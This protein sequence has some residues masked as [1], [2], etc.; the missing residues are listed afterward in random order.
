MQWFGDNQII[1]RVNFQGV[2]DLVVT[3]SLFPLKIGIGN[4]LLSK[5][6]LGL[7]IL[8]LQRSNDYQAVLWSLKSDGTYLVATR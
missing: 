5:W 3:K 4:D 2:Y 8:A 6:L 1:I 7:K